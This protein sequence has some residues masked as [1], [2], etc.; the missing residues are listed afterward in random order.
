MYKRQDDD[1]PAGIVIASMDA[2]A[3]NSADIS[4][5]Q[6]LAPASLDVTG[7]IA[8]YHGFDSSSDDKIPVSYTHLE[9]SHK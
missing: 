1:L 5:D 8:R 9:V 6:T 4:T 3:A 2:I 7:A